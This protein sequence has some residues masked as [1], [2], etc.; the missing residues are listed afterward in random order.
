MKKKLGVFV[1][2]SLIVVLGH[3]QTL[4]VNEVSQGPSGAKEYVEFLVA[5]TPGCGTNCM[6]L[7]GWIIDDNNGTYASG[8]GT[9]IAT[10]AIRFDP[11]NTFWECIPYGTLIVIYNESDPN[12]D[13]PVDDAS[14]VDG[15]CI[16]VIPANSSLLEGHA[17][18]PSSVG[19]SVY[20]TTGWTAASNWSM[21]AMSNSNDSFQ[22]VDPVTGTATSSVSW[23]NNTTSTI[24]YF[25]GS[26]GGSV[27]Y[28]DNSISDNYADQNNW[29]SGTATLG[30]TPG[31]P[32]SVLNAV[33]INGM[34]NSC[35]PIT[36]LIVSA[37]STDGCGCTGTGTA[38]SIGSIPGYTYE[39]FDN[40][41]VSIGQPVAAATG[42]CTGVYHVIGTSSTGCLDTALVA[43][44]SSPA[45][46]A[47]TA[48]AISFC[49]GDATQDLLGQLGGAPD[50]GGVWTGPSALTN[51]DLGT[52]DPATMTAGTYTYT[53]SA[54]GCSDSLQIVEV[55]VTS[56]C[57]VM[58]SIDYDSF[59]YTTT[60]PGIV[61]GAT[62]HTVPK[63]YSVRTGAS[64]VY[65]NFQNGYSGL[66]Y[67][68][69]YNTCIGQTYRLSAWLN[70]TFG[71]PPDND[72]QV[73]VYD[74]TGTIIYQVANLMV[75]AAWTQYNTG[76]FLATTTTIRF[77]IITNMLGGPGNDVSMDDLL[78]ERCG[79]APN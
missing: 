21:I 49:S 15:N 24:I 42:L 1:L 64:S 61:P 72:M 19:G 50:V 75:G 35:S 60:I 53:V 18:E 71:G 34:N 7:R 32:N 39:W 45:P 26:A 6:D 67:E 17:S 59:E 57:A 56:C 28:F 65:M 3:S 10:G 78:L 23:G 74:G 2:L 27:F 25:S 43:I 70:N 5:G 62:Y 41:Y 76:Q 68:R 29:I 66:A 36:P 44:L 14:L 48:G 51:G 58:D 4:I 33:F 38:S 40:S 12:P 55:Y 69:D 9:G 73:T 77:E 37:V 16:L 47:G 30:Q 54:S 63:S 13:L 11:A 52:F 46:N 79:M 22:V 20:L 8:T 31:A